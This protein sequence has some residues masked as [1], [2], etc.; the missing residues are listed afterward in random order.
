MQTWGGVPYYETSAR[1]QINVAEVFEDVL[2]QIIRCKTQCE[3][4]KR[5][6]KR[7]KKKRCI[8]L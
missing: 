5:R 6:T 1:Q 7:E 2:R 3:E 4:E 8:V